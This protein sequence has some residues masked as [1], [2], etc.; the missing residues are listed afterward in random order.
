MKN[1]RFLSQA[2]TYITASRPNIMSSNLCVASELTISRPAKRIRKRLFVPKLLFWPV[3]A[4]AL[5]SQSAYAAGGF[6]D[7][8]LEVSSFLFL[9]VGAMGRVWASAYISGRKNTELVTDGPY[10]M[11][12]N[13][14][15]FF[16]LLAYIG[17]GLAFAKI[18]VAVAFAV[19]FLLTHWT[20]I[21]AEERRLRERYGEQFNDYASRVPRFV[22]RFRT[23]EMPEFVTYRATIFNRA[24]LDCSLIMLCF[25]LGYLI[26]YGHHAGFLPVLLTNIP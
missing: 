6:W 2:I 17:A 19:L 12:R 3:I 21:L 13:P 9:L 25:V 16:S 24:V 22:P 1:C 10:S 11:T 20:T 18:T 8:T 4:F 7:T 14:L 26:K 5:V 23:L 15:Y